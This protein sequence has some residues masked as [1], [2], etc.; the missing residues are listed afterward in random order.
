MLFISNDETRYVLNG[1]YVEVR[2]GKR[3]VLVSTDGRRLTVIESQAEQDGASLLNFNLILSAAFLKPLLSFAKPL[4]LTLGVEY[5]PSERV[6]FHFIEAKCVIDAEAGGVINGA[7]P[8]WRKVVPSGTKKLLPEIGMN[9]DYVADYAKAA[10]FLGAAIPSLRINLFDADSVMEVQ[11]D[12]KPEFY[13]V[14]M[15]MQTDQARSWKPEFLGLSNE[16]EKLK[17]APGPTPEAQ[18]EVSDLAA[19]FTTKVN[20]DIKKKAKGVRLTSVRGES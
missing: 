1:V 4:T 14:L 20:A 5:H 17:R 19:Q 6:L 16:I 2:P 7:Y 8:D 13:S 15:P 9:A 11:I 10:K 12:S 3:P 18:K